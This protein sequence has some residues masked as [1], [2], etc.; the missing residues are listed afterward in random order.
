MEYLCKTNSEVCYVNVKFN[1][2]QSGL[3]ELIIAASNNFPAATLCE[4]HKL[5]LA[6]SLNSIDC[7]KPLVLCYTGYYM[8]LV[9]YSVIVLFLVVSGNWIGLISSPAGIRG[10]SVIILIYIF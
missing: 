3:G 9:S 7:M 5:L 10:L 4:G 1:F 6:S 8:L 2:C